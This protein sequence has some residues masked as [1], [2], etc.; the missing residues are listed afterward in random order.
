MSHKVLVAT[1]SFGSTSQKPWDV[2]ALGGCEVIRADM[3]QKMTEER[4]ME[5]LQGV[6]GAIVGVVPMTARVLQSATSL[7][8]ISAHGVGV[9]H[10]DVGA[11]RSLGI[12]V[13]NCP[14]TNDQAVADLAMGLMLSVARLIPKADRDMRN[15][16]WGSHIGTELWQ[17]TLGLVGF[18]RIGRAV[19][20][21]ALGFDM[22]V[23]A[24]DPYVSEDQA[25]TLGASMATLD[26]VIAEADFLSL[27]AVLT[28]ETRGMIDDAKLRKMKP[29]AFL[30]NTSRG[31]LLDE[32]ALYAAVAEKRIAGAA[33]DAFAVEP[34]WGSRLLQLDNV[35]VTPHLGAHTAEAI[36]RMGVVAAENVVRALQTGQPLYPV[37]G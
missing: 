32:E 27:H 17:K 29:T 21:R 35:V 15:G 20:K 6:D 11:A 30:I 4:L 37:E 2:L 34:P 5:L 28:D 13:A 14:G 26:T 19:A 24:Y 22:R 10:I 1:R 9:D 18:G 31:G 8:V 25:S 36:E 3:T 12:V 33:L 16:M 23:I 7:K